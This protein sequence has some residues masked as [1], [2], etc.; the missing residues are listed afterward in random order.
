MI[1]KGLDFPNITLVGVLTADTTLNLSDF[2]AAEKTFQLLTQVSGRAGRHDKPGEVF[3]QT[4]SPEHY[5]VQ[6][7][8]NHSYEPFY[9]QE[10][11]GR[12]QYE[13]PPFY[14]VTLIQFTHEDLMTVAD[15]AGKTVHWLRQRLSRES[16]VI[17]PTAAAIN[18]VNNRYRYQCLIKYKKEI[19][20]TETLQQLIKMYRTEWLKTGLL[21]SI[22]MDPSTIM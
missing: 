11:M 6:F 19:G 12:K 9:R 22:D 7:A 4:Y 15:Y 20:L 8:K 2:R 16:V 14:Y 21:M 1:A 10:M 17:G 13:Y 18:R 3:I 5:A